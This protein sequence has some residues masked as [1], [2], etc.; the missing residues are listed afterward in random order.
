MPTEEEWGY[1]PNQWIIGMSCICPRFHR[2]LT[3]V[4][5]L[6]LPSR[7]ESGTIL[8]SDCSASQNELPHSQEAWID[9]VL[10]VMQVPAGQKRVSA[11]RDG[12]MAPVL[13]RKR[14]WNVKLLASA[15]ESRDSGAK[16][17]T[18]R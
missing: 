15:S 10:A 14:S 18:A 11:A 13:D 17:L 6:C 4:P 2:Y 7:H 12:P 8:E 3:P 1:Q 9:L 16:D 5:Y